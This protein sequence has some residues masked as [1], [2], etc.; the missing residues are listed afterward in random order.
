MASYL[1]FSL[2]ENIYK[3]KTADGLLYTNEFANSRLKLSAAASNPSAY[4]NSGPT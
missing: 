2:G 3:M 1:R 4:N